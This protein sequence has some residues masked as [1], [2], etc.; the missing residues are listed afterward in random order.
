MST[1]RK[2][3]TGQL[4]GSINFMLHGGLE[5]VN[6]N[7]SSWIE[8]DDE[9]LVLLIDTNKSLGGCIAKIEESITSLNDYLNSIAEA[10]QQKDQ[11]LS[12]HISNFSEAAISEGQSEVAKSS[13][14][15][16]YFRQYLD[17]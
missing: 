13:T 8:A 10:F 14:S 11:E 17:N 9:S 4:S 15:V 3:D 5:A 6:E 12:T 7:A 1:E 16:G 2:I